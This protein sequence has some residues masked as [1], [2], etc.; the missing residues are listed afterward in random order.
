ML[1]EKG[2][3]DN[4]QL[5]TI[6]INFPITYLFYGPIGQAMVQGITKQDMYTMDLRCK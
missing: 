6:F 5:L 1:H 3:L 4:V 2:E